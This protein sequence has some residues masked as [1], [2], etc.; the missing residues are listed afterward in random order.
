[1]T[2]AA[3][4]NPTGAPAMDSDGRLLS[5]PNDGVVAG[6][7]RANENI[8]LTATHTLFAREHNR[9]VSLLPASLSDED[10]FQIAR[11]VVIAEEQ[12]ITY[13]EWLPAMGVALPKYTGYNA[14][15]NATLSNEFATVGYRAHT[16]IHGDGLEIDNQ[17]ASRYSA[18]DIAS[19]EAQG[20]DV[21]DNGDGT[22][23]VDVPLG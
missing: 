19:L 20:L 16:Q 22:V 23:S 10:K 3:R 5:H 18:A 12:Y 8:A 2:R 15:V 14:N 17:P 4:G 9:I 11:R 6:D 21:E 13:H 1:P 7:A